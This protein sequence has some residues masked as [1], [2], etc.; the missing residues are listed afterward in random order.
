MLRNVSHFLILTHRIMTQR[1]YVNIK[2]KVMGTGFITLQRGCY[3]YMSSYYTILRMANKR[4]SLEIE[5]IQPS[6]ARRASL[7]STPFTHP[8]NSSSLLTIGI[9]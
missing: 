6:K 1:H 4:G 8:G 9:I 3:Y 2:V 5:K 7:L